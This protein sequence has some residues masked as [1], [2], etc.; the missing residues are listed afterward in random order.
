MSTK[1]SPTTKIKIDSIFVGKEK[2]M[3]LLIR[4]SILLALM[5]FTFNSI[6]VKA[7]PYY[8]N[9]NGVK[10]NKQEY[11]KILNIM[12][13]EQIAQLT[14][15]TFEK[16]LSAVI[17]D[18]QVIYQKVKNTDKE[19]ISEE[20]ITEEEFNTAPSVEYICENDNNENIRSSDYGYIETTYKKFNASLSD[21]GNYFDFSASLLWKR[22]PAC[23]SYD[24]FAFRVIHMS[25]SDMVGAQTYYV[26]DAGTSIGYNDTSPGYKSATNGAGF[27]MNLKDDSNIT[28]FLMYITAD[29]NI[30]EYNYSTA[31]V[32][33]TYQ[34][35]ISSLTRSQSMNY[36]F[37]T[38]G[39][40]NVVYYSNYNIMQKYDD[41][42]GLHLTTSI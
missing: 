29:L 22:V 24:V 4:T 28:K 32:Y 31:H 5:L 17:V 30:S 8:T 7:E 13:E 16:Y 42:E 27:S 20:Y 6:V 15:D 36:T 41:M 40:G 19:I 1:S 12:P 9:D 34:H 35:A 23:R 33:T 14:Q 11:E 25:Y 18:R 10:M 39:L 37:S 26:G 21:F 38:A 2:S 3:K